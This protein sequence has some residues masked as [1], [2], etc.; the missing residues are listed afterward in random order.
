MIARKFLVLGAVLAALASRRRA[1]R[2]SWR[3]ATCCWRRCGRSARSS[4]RATRSP[5]SR[6]PGSGSTRRWPTR[7]GRR[8]PASRRATSRTCRR[9]SCSTSTRRV[10]D[11]SLYQVWMMKNN[12]TFS[13]KTW[14]EFCAA[15]VSLRDPRRRRVHQVR[16]FQGREGLLHQ[17]SRRRDREGHAREHGEARLPDGR[18]RRHLPDAEREAGMGQRQEHAPRRGRPRTIASC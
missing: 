3:P 6:W 10:L 13:T 18:Q 1:G 17:Q 7:A 8:R 5:S 9:P 15:Q 12:Q 16:R 14:N 11:N 4:T 2:R